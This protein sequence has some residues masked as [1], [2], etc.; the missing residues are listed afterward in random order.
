MSRSSRLHRDAPGLVGKVVVVWLLV[1]AVLGVAA[2]D[3]GSIMLTKFHLSDVATNAATEGANALRDS[4]DENKACQAAYAYVASQ[5]ATVKISKQ[6]CV[7]NSQAG[8]VSITVH[9]VAKTLLAGRF[10]FSKEYTKVSATE[11]NTSSTL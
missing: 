4:H 11:T 3:A 7:V 2:I 1:L 8:T 10:A 9:K 6:G 5:D